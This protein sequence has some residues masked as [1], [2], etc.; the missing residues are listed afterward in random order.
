MSAGDIDD[1]INAATDPITK[2]PLKEGITIQSSIR[3][4]LDE[5]VDIANVLLDNIKRARG[6]NE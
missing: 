5:A 6:C 2:K 3:L 1:F 4:P